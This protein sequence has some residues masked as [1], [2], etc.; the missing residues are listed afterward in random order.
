MLLRII[1]FFCALLIGV[2]L[3]WIGRYKRPDL[4]YYLVMP[5]IWAHLEVIFLGVA[6][7]RAAGYLPTNDLSIM[8]LNNWSM[9]NK[10]VGALTIS[11]DM[12]MVILE[13]VVIAREIRANGEI[14]R[15]AIRG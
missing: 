12:S 3:L 14:I 11:I 9:V 6:I 15:N 5:M 2:V 7:L 10:L 4:K 8:I 1:V 13:H